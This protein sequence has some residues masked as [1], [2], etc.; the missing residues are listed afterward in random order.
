MPESTSQADCVGDLP[1]IE[2]A[3]VQGKRVLVR[4]DLNVT[5]R[6]GTTQIADDSRIH[7]SIPTIRVLCERGARVVLCSH[8]GRP[9]GTVV[10]ELSIVHVQTRAQELLGREIQCLGGPVGS[11][12]QSAVARLHDGEVGI[13]ENL[14]FHPGEES[15]TS[16]FSDALTSLADIYVLDAF[17]AAHR[18]HASIAG[19]P[20]LIPTYAGILMR[21]EIAALTRAVESHERPAVAI[22]GGAKVSD[23]L[24]VIR[25]IAKRVDHVLIGGGMVRA[26]FAASAINVGSAEVPEDEVEATRSL[27]EDPRVRESLRLPVDVILAERWSA[28]AKFEIVKSD[29]IES[30]GFILDIGPETVRQYVDLIA[31]ARKVIWNGPMG[32]FEWPSFAD[33]T[34]RVAQGIAKNRDAYTVAGGGSTVEAIYKFDAEDA[35]THISTGGGASLQFLEGK[36]LPGVAALTI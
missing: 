8:L 15:N 22:L 2:D 1:R 9:R 17:G 6:P 26:F 12:V 24:T 14:R 31:S 19:A 16:E 25:N 29:A 35:F 27:L 34:R 33:G 11:R 13:V 30:Q 36:T 23:K 4:C 3:D 10:P 32:L 18:A 20:G 21:A 7:E 28:D 5:F